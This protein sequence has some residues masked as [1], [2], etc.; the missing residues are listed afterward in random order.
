V[1]RVY[2]PND[3]YDGGIPPSVR[4]GRDVYVDTSY[5]FAGCQTERD[6][7]VV[8]GDSAGV[9]DRT[10]FW[11][12]RG[13]RV[14][15]GAFTCLN[16]TSIVC[17]ESIDIGAHCLM[18]WGVVITDTWSATP[19]SIEN[20]RIAL[21]AAACDPSR[22]FGSSPSS[23]PV[24]IED[25]VWIGFDSVVLPGVRLGR[26]SVIGCKTVIYADVPPY[27]V[28]AGSPARMVRHL[29]PTDSR[30]SIDAAFQQF[31]RREA[32]TH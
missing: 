6:P 25:N 12:G 3:W 5:A 10:S 4:M 27:A 15:V 19:L 29:D 28:V 8:L 11:I 22:V 9:Y 2:L 7:G 1:N 23:R 32:R 14:E 17:H 26:G 31:M 21:R 16:A 24:V 13:G 18:A 30:E 20:R